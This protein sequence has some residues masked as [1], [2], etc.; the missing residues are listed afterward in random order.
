MSVVSG[1]RVAMI[2][3]CSTGIGRATA[4]RLDSNGWRVY[5]GVRKQVDADGLAAAGS[6]RLTPLIVDVT[7]PASVA[8]ARERIGMEA[9]AGLHALVN[10]A[11]VAYTGPLEFVP[12]EDFRRQLE[13]NLLGQVEMMQA[14]IPALRLTRGR[15]VNI[16]SIGGIV[17]TPFFGPYN[18]SKYALEAVSD[19]LR[20]ELRPW[21]IETIVIEPGSVATEIWESGVDQFGETKERMAPEVQT[22][23]GK[24]LKA[25]IRTSMETGERGIPADHAAAVIER[26]LNAKRPRARYRIGRDAHAMAAAS[27]LLPDRVFDRLIA[28]AMRIP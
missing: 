28:R 23:Y 6:E 9:P 27:S 22:L 13:V 15:I 7:D 21:G 16:T 2:T 18:A 25:L 19:C 8:G 14:L 11:G 26:A 1:S 12:L 10:N 24:A 3:G 17:A 20:G 5:A 4:L